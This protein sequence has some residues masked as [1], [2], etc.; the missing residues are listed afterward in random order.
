MR[1][2]KTGELLRADTL[3]MDHIHTR[4]KDIR[5]PPLMEEEQELQDTLHKLPKLTIDEIYP[6]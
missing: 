5:N 2:K 6:L 1:C 3:L 4:L